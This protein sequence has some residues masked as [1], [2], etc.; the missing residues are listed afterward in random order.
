MSAGAETAAPAR[1]G[2]CGPRALLHAWAFE[3]CAATAAIA[4][5]LSEQTPRDLPFFERDASLSRALVPSTVPTSALVA[6][7][8]VL[9]ATA[10]V[11]FFTIAGARQHKSLAVGVG[12][13]ATVLTPFFLSVSLTVLT[14]NL[15]KNVVG[16]KRPNFLAKCDYNGLFAVA[17]SSGNFTAYLASTSAAAFGS[18]SRCAGTAANIVDGQRSFPSGHSSLSFAGLGFLALA[19]RFAF[20]VDRAFFSPAALLAASPLALATYIA[21]SRIIDGYHNVDDVL[22]GSI[23]GAFFAN[24]A[25]AHYLRSRETWKE[26]RVFNV[27][28]LPAEDLPK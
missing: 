4:I 24:I 11:L 21:C 10:L 3:V 20:R 14:T 8:V 7:G 27:G 26:L 15:I 28:G 12:A 9:P 18:L 17:A 1:T 2:R 19:A 25:W 6:L 22:T 5:G 16:R 13:A 23:I